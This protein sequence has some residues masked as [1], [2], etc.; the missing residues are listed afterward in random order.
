MKKNQAAGMG[1]GVGGRIGKADASHT[2]KL[3]WRSEV[4]RAA[5]SERPGFPGT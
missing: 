2:S 4:G 3:S 5:V 1:W